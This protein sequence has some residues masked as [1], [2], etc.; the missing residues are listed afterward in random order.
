M[1]NKKHGRLTAW[2]IVMIMIFMSACSS[3]EKTSFETPTEEPSEVLEEIHQEKKPDKEIA[4]LFTGNLLGNATEESD[5]KSIKDRRDELQKSGVSVDI[6][7]CGN[8]VSTDKSGN[9]EDAIATLK[10]MAAVGYSYVN[11]SMHEFD[12]GIDGLRKMAAEKPEAL[13]CNFR[14]SGFGDDVTQEVARYGITDFDG[15]KVGYVAVTDP[16][17]INSHRDYLT[18]DGRTAYSFCG[19]STSYLAETVQK[20]VDMCR[21]EEADY[22]FVLSGFVAGY[23]I[24]MLELAQLTVGVDGYLY[25]LGN[26]GEENSVTDGQFNNVPLAGVGEGADSFGEVRISK[27]GGISFSLK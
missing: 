22:V 1:K 26:E 10:S 11:V 4:I 24:T 6:V 14:Y 16:E 27:D 25:S 9:I 2:L 7:D 3:E 8:H 15:V 21:S 18:E 19:R 20:Y 12:Y 5:F 13:S 17:V 23:G